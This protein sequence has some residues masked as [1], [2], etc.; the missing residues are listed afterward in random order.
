[1][2]KGRIFLSLHGKVPQE[3]RASMCFQYLHSKSLIKRMTLFHF[4]KNVLL[5]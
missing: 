2:L 1:M 3:K 5:Y 4:L